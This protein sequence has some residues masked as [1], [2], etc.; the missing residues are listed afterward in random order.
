MVVRPFNDPDFDLLK[1]LQFGCSYGVGPLRP[2]HPGGTVAVSPSTLTTPATFEWFAYNSLVA[3]DGVR[4]RVSPELEYFHGSFGF[5]TQYFVMNQ[6]LLAGELAGK[7]IVT[8]HTDGFYV[9]A[10]YLL[11]GEQRYDY[12]E[13]IDPITPFSPHSP[14]CNPQRLGNILWRVSRLD[15]SPNAL[16]L[17]FSATG[18]GSREATG[19]TFGVNWYLNKW[20]RTQFNWEHAWFADPVKIGQTVSRFR[21]TMERLLVYS[22]PDYILTANPALPTGT[23]TAGRPATCTP[24]ASCLRF[25]SGRAADRKPG[26]G[27]D[28]LQRGE[29]RNWGAVV[30]IDGDEIEPVGAIQL[31]ERC[32]RFLR[33]AHQLSHLAYISGLA[34]ARQSALV[35]DDGLLH[36]GH[37]AFDLDGGG[38]QHSMGLHHV[39]GYLVLDNA[40][41]D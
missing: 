32:H 3:A 8:V 24:A 29:S 18:L 26:C 16:T 9:M 14:I 39:L 34:D 40:E 30:V 27:P 1:G 17:T 28:I 15:M 36:A 33:A 5:A 20:V 6:Q 38:L 22:F 31:D 37:R 23:D 19:S 2:P 7:P 13:Q 35:G 25:R 11:T 10:S 21:C 41:V 4:T 12:T